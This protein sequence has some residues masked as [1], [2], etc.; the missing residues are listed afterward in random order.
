M[1]RKTR[2]ALSL[3][4]T[5]IR[6]DQGTGSSARVIVR[7]LHASVNLIVGGE[8]VTPSTGFDVLPGELHDDV[9]NPKTEPLYGC[10]ASGT[11]TVN[12]MTSDRWA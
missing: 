1:P 6:L 12:V 11:I 2:K 3:T 10:A 9:F 8:G 4:T 7:N 5:A